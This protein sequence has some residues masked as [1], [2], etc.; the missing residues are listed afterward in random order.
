MRF[1]LIPPRES[2]RGTHVRSALLGVPALDPDARTARIHQ[3]AAELR[4][5]PEHML[6]IMWTDLAKQRVV[7]LPRAITAREVAAEA[8]VRLI[9][10]IFARSFELRLA[11]RD[12]ATAILRAAAVRGLLATSQLATNPSTGT[13]PSTSTNPTHGASPTRG[14]NPTRANPAPTAN[15]MPI[16]SPSLVAD[17]TTELTISGPLTVF[18]R[19]TVYGRTLC[20]LV[21][22]L[23][24][25]RRFTLDAR[26]D[27]GYGP[28]VFRIES[29]VILPPPPTE[30]AVTPTERKFEKDLAKL[31]PAWTVERTP[32]AYVLRKDNQ[33]WHVEIVGY[34]TAEYLTTK[35]ASHT[36][37]VILCIDAARSLSKGELPAEARI[38][39]FEGRVPVK[40]VVALIER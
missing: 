32:T 40:D 5:S 21:R 20:A 4:T 15:P 10:R 17:S 25:S 31:A 38:V 9:Q 14:A 13:N 37:N 19:T 16:A 23:S 30:R 6:Q 36:G 8:N 2:L 1:L 18:H 27:L 29:P 34:W 24:A 33:T 22:H 35:L 11:V 26:C 3:V 12:D 7:E 39:R 28:T